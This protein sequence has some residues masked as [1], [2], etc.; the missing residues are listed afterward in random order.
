MY[1]KQKR[2][3][4]RRFIDLAG[5]SSPLMTAVGRL[6]LL[7]VLNFCWLLCSLPLITAGAATTALWSVLLERDEY[8]YF[9]AIP[10]FFRAFRQHLKAATILWIP[11]LV[12]GA[13]LLLDFA[14]LAQNNALNN[15]LLLM[16]L[17]LAAALWGMTQLWLFSLLTRDDTLS[18]AAAVRAAFLTALR[19]LWRSLA[20]LVVAAAPVVIFLLYGELFV[21]LLPLWV[22]LG[23]SLPARLVLCLTEPILTQ[24]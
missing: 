13:V 22:L 16:P 7:V 8:S 5:D 19:E 2:S 11:Y 10:A 23:A 15:T 21:Q 4:F 3:L 17:L 24:A 6:M 14:L 20:G 1:L 18:P 12:I 9:S